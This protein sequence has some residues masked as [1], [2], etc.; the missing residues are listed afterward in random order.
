[1]T[2]HQK[3]MKDYDKL[4]H[5]YC[6]ELQM[7]GREPGYAID[8]DKHTKQLYIRVGG[9]HHI[10][11]PKWLKVGA[12]VGYKYSQPTK[13]RYIIDGYSSE[14]GMIYVIQDGLHEKIPL[15][16]LCAALEVGML[17]EVP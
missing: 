9:C 16:E 13:V 10:S 2:K 11:T 8:E 12:K 6:R 7:T 5:D 15:F 4:I 1:M 17:V 14:A 3:I